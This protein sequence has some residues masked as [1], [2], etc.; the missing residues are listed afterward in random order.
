MPKM[1][2]G[3]FDEK[4]GLALEYVEGAANDLTEVKALIAALGYSSPTLVDPAKVHDT[5]R[6]VVGLVRSARRD[7]EKA[8]WAASDLASPLSFD[9]WLRQH[10]YDDLVL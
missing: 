3:Y 2:E 8:R 5:F 1:E 9:D 6:G 4:R 7:Y 10:G